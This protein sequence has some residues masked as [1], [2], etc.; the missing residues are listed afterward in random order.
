[1]TTNT[2]ILKLNDSLSK[3]RIY[4]IYLEVKGNEGYGYSDSHEC[5]ESTFS[6]TIKCTKDVILTSELLENTL[7][8]YWTTY[9]FTRVEFKDVT[10]MI[11]ELELLRI[12][13]D[14]FDWNSKTYE[15]YETITDKIYD[16]E[17]KIE[18]NYFCAISVD[19]TI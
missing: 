1:M 7:D 6:G 15:E 11:K 17:N 5:W 10:E 2:V 18:P 13:A 19:K 4:S 12:E 9:K 14:E 8:T 16:L 3:D